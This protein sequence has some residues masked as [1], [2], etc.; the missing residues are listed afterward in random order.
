[1]KAPLGYMT[2][3]IW[4]QRQSGWSHDDFWYSLEYRVGYDTNKC[5]LEPLGLPYARADAKSALVECGKSK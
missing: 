4:R 2:L 1:M 3:S 5:F